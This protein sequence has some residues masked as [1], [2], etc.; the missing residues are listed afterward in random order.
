VVL[1]FLQRTGRIDPQRPAGGL[2]ARQQAD[3]EQIRGK[4]QTLTQNT[5]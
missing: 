2:D 1:R 3:R 4:V 5:V